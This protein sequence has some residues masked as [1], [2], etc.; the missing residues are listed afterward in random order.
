MT[1]KKPKCVG[2]AKFVAKMPFGDCDPEWDLLSFE[3]EVKIFYLPTDKKNWWLF[4]KNFLNV[5]LAFREFCISYSFKAL[6]NIEE[7]E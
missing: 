1:L 2:F 5:F 6:S 3:K 7:N 4:Q